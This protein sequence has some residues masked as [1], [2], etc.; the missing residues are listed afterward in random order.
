MVREKEKPRKI[1][2]ADYF[3]KSP[4]PN[5]EN[6]EEEENQKQSTSNDFADVQNLKCPKRKV[7]IDDEDEPEK[8]TPRKR[9]DAIK[10][11]AK[12]QRVL[13][14]GQKKIGNITCDICQMVYCV[15]DAADVAMHDKYH[16]AMRFL[17]EIPREFS[18][19]ILQFPHRDMNEV[20]RVYYLEREKAEE[21]FK[22][23]MNKHIKNV[24]NLLGYVGKDADDDIWEGDKRIFIAL[25]RNDRRM[26]IGGILIVE[27][28][29]NAWTNQSQR[30]IGGGY[31]KSDWIV[32]VDRIYVD[33][34][35]RRNK[36]ASHLLDAATTQTQEMQFR[37][38]RLR[39]AMSDPSDDAI[40]LAKAFLE[41]RYMEK[42]QFDGEILI[43]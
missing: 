30:E 22:K 24:N 37:D 16:E 29:A 1:T 13:D 31:G 26:R 2:I 4:K 6:V 36:I 20:L 14:A 28:I 32:G 38:R 11:Q 12:G 17:F 42:D 15:D 21:P 41:T 3:Q 35:C 10:K 23:L 19:Q 39:M 34:F 27:K 5:P 43:Y 9:G 33:P 25:A 7:I 18:F 40:K 8:K